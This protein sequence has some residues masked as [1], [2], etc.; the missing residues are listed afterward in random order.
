MISTMLVM[1]PEKVDRLCSMLC[2]SPIS[3]NTC[4]NTAI[5]VPRSAGTCRPACAIS[6]N[7]PTVFRVTVL[8]PVFGPVITRVVNSSPSQMLDGTTFSGSISGCRPRMMFRYP[9]SLIFGLTQTSRR[10][11]SPLAKMKSSSD[12]SSTVSAIAGA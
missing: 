9:R 2:S 5:S 3:A 4:S 11:S 12:S 8:P 7:S 1:W 10:L 6:V